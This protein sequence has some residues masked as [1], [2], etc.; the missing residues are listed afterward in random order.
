MKRSALGCTASIMVAG[1]FGLIDAAVGGGGIARAFEFAV[2]DPAAAGL[3][4]PLLQEW[5]GEP[6][7]VHALWPTTSASRAAKVR[8]FLEFAVGLL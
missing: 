2:R 6:Q 3:L 1:V 5:G 8:V 4:R 7:L